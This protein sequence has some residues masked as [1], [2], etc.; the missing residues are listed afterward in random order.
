[1]TR[2]DVATL[3]Q[4]PAGIVGQHGMRPTPCLPSSHAVSAAPWLRGRVSSTQTCRSMPGIMRHVDRCQRSA[5]IDGGQPAGVAMRQDV[6]ALRRVCLP[7]PV[8]DQRQAM[9]GRS[10]RFCAT[11]S[12]AIM[13]AST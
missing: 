3:H 2:F 11:S 8:F 5:P 13:A 6:D 10:L 4:V 7:Q 1:M 12:S 9:P